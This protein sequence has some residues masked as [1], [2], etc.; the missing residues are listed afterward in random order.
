MLYT[1]V[2]IR[3]LPKWFIKHTVIHLRRLYSVSFYVAT[4]ISYQRIIFCDLLEN[5]NDWDGLKRKGTLEPCLLYF[6]F[7]KKEMVEEREERRT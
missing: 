4:Y 3:D 1:M 7:I 6:C 5:T 2:I